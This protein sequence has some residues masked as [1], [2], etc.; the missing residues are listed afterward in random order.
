MFVHIN[1]A[2][3][4]NM[5]ELSKMRSLEGIYLTN[6]YVTN[7]GLKCLLKLK[8]LRTLYLD[9]SPINAEGLM[10]LG[11]IKSLKYLDVSGTSL[12]REDVDAFMT[13]NPNCMVFGIG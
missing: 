6:S 3:N 13:F 1:N 5:K 11:K 10:S 8:K 4:E 9:L 2:T 7:E 12:T